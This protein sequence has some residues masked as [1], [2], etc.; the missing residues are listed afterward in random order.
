M[1]DLYRL[2]DFDMDE[3]SSFS[4]NGYEACIDLTPLGV[5][6]LPESKPE[7]K[8]RRPKGTIGE[9]RE[10]HIWDTAIKHRIIGQ[11][12]PTMSA[13]EGA[14]KPLIVDYIVPD[15]TGVEML[16]AIA[17]KIGLPARTPK[18]WQ[19]WIKTNTGKLPIPTPYEDERRRLRA[20]ASKAL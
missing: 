14:R 1:I 15:H 13:G 9:R 4:P 10:R 6:L 16:N 3:F 8:R 11:L 17:A 7:P 12:S 5:E 19:A 2:L 18:K 20:R